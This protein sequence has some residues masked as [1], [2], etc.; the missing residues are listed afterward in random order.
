[1]AISLS[2]SPSDVSKKQGLVSL[3]TEIMALAALSQTSSTAQL[4]AQKQTSLVYGCMEIGQVAA[5]DIIAAFPL[6]FTS[7]WLATYAPTI[8]ILAASI[9][10]NPGIIG[11][12]SLLSSARQQA[13]ADALK[14]G[15]VDGA[16][17]LATLVAP[18]VLA[19]FITAVGTTGQVSF[20]ANTLA[21]G[22]F[23]TIS[24]TYG[25]TGSIVG[26][27]N[28]KSYLVKATNGTTTAQL[29]N[30]DGTAIATTAG[31]PTGIT[32]TVHSP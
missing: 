5:A 2:T 3:Q 31:T 1:M 4:L 12:G 7:G 23:V 19:G 26:Y 13:V 11:L 16:T 17:I 25:G 27:T 9:T 8:A 29:M 10:A 21:V 32:V 15:I 18:H 28:P 30:I 14:L 24:G 6:Q 20:T 22:Q